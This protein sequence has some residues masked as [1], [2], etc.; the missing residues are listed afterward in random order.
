LAWF[1][2]ARF[3]SFA[4]FPFISKSSMVRGGYRAKAK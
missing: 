1:L 4:G 3:F 2:A